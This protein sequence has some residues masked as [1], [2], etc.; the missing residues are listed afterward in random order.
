MQIEISTPGSIEVNSSKT[1]E[2]EFVIT[3]ELLPIDTLAVAT[4]YS[5]LTNG[6]K[7]DAT[8][9]ELYKE[10]DSNLNYH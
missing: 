9:I 5:I 2:T 10:A 1:I 8:S 4:V 7:S 3:P 6:S